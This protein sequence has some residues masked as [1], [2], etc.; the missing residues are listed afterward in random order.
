LA[1]RHIFWW[2]AYGWL[3]RVEKREGIQEYGL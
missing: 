1:S 3:G 2:D